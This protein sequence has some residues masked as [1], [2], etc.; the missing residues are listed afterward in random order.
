MYIDSI[1]IGGR[2]DSFG[3]VYLLL[4]YKFDYICSEYLQG[5]EYVIK[6]YIFL[7]FNKSFA[8]SWC[9]WK[10]FLERLFIRKQKRVLCREIMLPFP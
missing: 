2:Y 3:C 10:F 8:W 7:D 1:V 9:F 5:T 4:N 6:L